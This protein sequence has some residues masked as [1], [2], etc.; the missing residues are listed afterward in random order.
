MEL[1][2]SSIAPTAATVALPTALVEL[3]SAL[4]KLVCVLHEDLSKTRE[5]FLVTEDRRVS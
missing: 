4:F 5:A 3:A 2:I 1:W